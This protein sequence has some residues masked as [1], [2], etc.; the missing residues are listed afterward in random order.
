MK[1]LTKDEA[2]QAVNDGYVD[3]Y[4]YA[5]FDEAFVKEGLITL[6]NAGKIV[7]WAL[8]AGDATHSYKIVDK[9]GNDDATGSIAMFAAPKSDVCSGRPAIYQPSS[10][11]ACPCLFIQTCP[12]WA[13]GSSSSRSSLLELDVLT[14]LYCTTIEAE[15]KTWYCLKLYPVR[16]EYKDAQ[17]FYVTFYRGDAADGV[18]SNG[19]SNFNFY[20]ENTS[21]Q[22]LWPGKSCGSGQDWSESSYW[23]TI[24]GG[25]EVIADPEMTLTADKTC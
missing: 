5:C 2:Q 25:V 13:Y 3:L 6:N 8:L 12:T 20:A 14:N 22:L 23:G 15:G 1:Q 16:F 18:T 11:G 4:A 7:R 19:A 9:D 21:T 17:S 24:R 10:G